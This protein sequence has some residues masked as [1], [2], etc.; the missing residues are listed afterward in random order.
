MRDLVIR[1]ATLLGETGADI[2]IS[3]GIFVPLD[4]VDS[5]AKVLSAEGLLALPG[6]VDLHTHLRQP[7]MEHAET[8][9]TGSQAAAL[10]GYTAVHAMA[11]TTPTTDSPE[12]VDQVWQWEIGRAHV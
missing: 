5:D 4:A 6:L 3:H 10:G 12:R 2:A 9:L 1:G 8:V 7:G 11:N